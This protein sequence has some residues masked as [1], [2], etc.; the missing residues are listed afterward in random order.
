VTNLVAEREYQ[1]KLLLAGHAPGIAQVRAEDF[2]LPTG[3]T[4]LEVVREVTLKPRPPSPAAPAPA[5]QK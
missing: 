1:F 4:R 3:E 5:P 2:L